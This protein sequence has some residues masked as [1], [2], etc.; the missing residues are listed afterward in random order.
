MENNMENNELNEIK[1]QLE[2]T[3]KKIDQA[4]MESIETLR[5]TVDAK[6][7]YT[8]GHSER[9]SEYAVLLG[10]KLQINSDELYTLRIGGLFHDI[11]KIG[12]TDN[13]LSKTDKLTDSEY[14]EIKKHPLIGTQILSKASIFSDIL[15][16]VKYHH[17][18]YDGTGYPD[19]LKGEEIPYLARIVSV[20]DAFDAMASR[21]PY[22][23]T[24]E[25]KKIVDEI[26]INKNKQFD[27]K[28]ADALLDII[29]NNY[30]ALEEI[31]LRYKVDNN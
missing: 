17:E 10:K 4:Y 12:I 26:T 19:K 5:Y 11:G 6:D 15:P 14:E 31:Q 22:R 28:I 7:S 23:D 2:T 8:K 18:R 24:V 20:A 29:K 27:P 3:Q 30:S 1:N 16:I 25:I 21:R 13:I 9:V